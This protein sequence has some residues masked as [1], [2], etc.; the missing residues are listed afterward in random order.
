MK[1]DGTDVCLKIRSHPGPGKKAAGLLGLEDVLCLV[2][3]RLQEEQ[4]SA[5]DIFLS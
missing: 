1:F 3:K 4:E 5:I 2:M